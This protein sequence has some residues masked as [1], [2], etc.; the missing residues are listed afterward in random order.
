MIRSALYAAVLAAAVTVPA[1]AQLQSYGLKVGATQ[2]SIETELPSEDPVSRRGTSWTL[3]GEWNVPGPVSLVTEAGV[4]ERGY[5]RMASAQPTVALFESTVDPSEYRLDRRM[6][7]VSVA[8]LARLPL[9]SAGPVSAYAFAGPR[10]NTLIGRRGED[11]DGGM[12]GY[13]YRSVAWDATAGV[14]VEGSGWLPVV[15]EAR[16]NRGINNAFNDDGWG[17]PAYHRAVDVMVGVKF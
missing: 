1:S 8:A 3:F 4:A 9:V 15:V 10:M 7:Y 13:T 5:A 6:Q 17:E 14:G 11:S 2:S 16:Y 12:A